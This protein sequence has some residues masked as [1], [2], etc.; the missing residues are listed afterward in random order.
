[1]NFTKEQLEEVEKYASITGRGGE[2][3]F[4]LPANI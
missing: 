1:M 2:I 3:C 4:Y